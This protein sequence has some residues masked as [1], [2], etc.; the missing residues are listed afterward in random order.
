MLRVCKE[1]THFM[2]AHIKTQF[3]I[4]LFVWSRARI[5]PSLRGFSSRSFFIFHNYYSR[6]LHTAQPYDGFFISLSF[7]VW[8]V[9]VG[10]WSSEFRV[11][12]LA[13]NYDDDKK[14]L[15]YT[16]SILFYDLSI[17]VISFVHIRLYLRFSYVDNFY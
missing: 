4:T 15:L 12:R 5:S 2:W 14:Q 17:K 3:Q 6:V 8:Y 1:D 7:F 13:L 9:H 16:V 10:A 11:C